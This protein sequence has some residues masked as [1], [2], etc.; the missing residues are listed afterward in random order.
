[1]DFIDIKSI[2]EYTGLDEIINLV[3]LGI[4]LQQLI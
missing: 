3:W 2:A 4:L 1:M